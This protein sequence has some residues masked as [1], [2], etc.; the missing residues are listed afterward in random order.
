MPFKRATRLKNHLQKQHGTEAAANPVL[1]AP[2]DRDGIGETLRYPSSAT[3]LAKSNCADEL[4]Y[5]RCLAAVFDTGRQL[6]SCDMIDV[7]D[8]S[9]GRHCGTLAAISHGSHT[10]KATNSDADNW[11]DEISDLLFSQERTD[12][13]PLPIPSLVENSITD[14]VTTSNTANVSVL[15]D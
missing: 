12:L 5:S 8:D 11:N 4:Y 2:A 3:D 6:E 15:R 14:I 9:P 7:Q 1:L 13:L 10:T